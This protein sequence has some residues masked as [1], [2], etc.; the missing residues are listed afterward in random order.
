MTNRESSTQGSMAPPMLDVPQYAAQPCCLTDVYMASLH[1]SQRRSSRPFLTP[2]GSGASNDGDATPPRL[3]SD[4]FVLRALGQSSPR[5][6]YVS[7]GA[8]PRSP[9]TDTGSPLSPPPLQ[10]SLACR[11]FMPALLPRRRRPTSEGTG[12]FLTR[13]RFRSC[14]DS[15]HAPSAQT[16]TQSLEPMRSLGLPSFRPQ[17]DMSLVS[18]HDGAE[19]RRVSASSPP[20]ARQRGYSAYS[21]HSR[22][23]DE[24][25]SEASF[26]GTLL[27]RSQMSWEG[28][29]E[30]TGTVGPAG[31]ATACE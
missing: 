30:T 21:L 29:D 8:V 20:P 9:S 24:A 27:F 22:A 14:I 18:Q 19:E 25:G 13:S 1:R 3:D 28:E 15:C 5:S 2:Q 11:A 10:Q 23:A 6:P 7:G 4:V 26:S 12:D 16:P 31:H 17:G